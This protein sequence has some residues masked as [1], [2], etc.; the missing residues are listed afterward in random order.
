MEIPKP[1]T[2]LVSYA[3]SIDQGKSEK[4]FTMTAMVITPTEQIPLILPTG[5]AR[6][7]LFGVNHSDDSQIKANI[8]PGV[9]QNSILPY[10][11][12]LF[13]EVIER[14]GYVQTMY[15]YRAF[16]LG[17]SSAPM[18]ATN[19]SMADLT[20]KDAINMVSVK[21]QLL[22]V[23]YAQLRTV[24]ISDHLLM[25]TLDKVLHYQ[26]TKYGEQLN[27]TGGDKWLGV[28]I[29]YPYDNTRIFKQV[30]IP[31]AIPLVK[32]ADFLQQD[33]Q[34]GFYS[35]GMG[36]YY[37][38]G[39]WYIFPP[40]KTGRYE[41]ARKVAN[42]YALPENVFPTLKNSWFLDEKVLTILSTGQGDNID[43]SDIHKLNHG[44]GKRVISSDAIMGEVGRYYAKGQG[45]TTREDSLSEY[46]TSER[47]SGEENIPYH[48]TPTN[49]L[50]KLLS[51]NAYT[52]G[53][54]VSRTWHNSNG[55]EIEPGMPCR[56]YFMNGSDA[57][58]YRE[59]TIVSIRS[60]YQQDTQSVGQP[61]FR[62]HSTL[63]MFLAN[64]V[65]AVEA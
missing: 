6:L 34:F 38:K 37:R 56:Y 30:I 49:N 45:L 25:T 12:N 17:D 36:S 16:P 62:E 8:Q 19:T 50:C 46:K 20:T 13:I 52:D 54:I 28:D 44:S 29:E 65:V 31:A 24:M 59:G 64:D 11:D 41:K 35:R 53:N 15:R 26:L 7:C 4:L 39:M 63:E 43:G 47:S 22:D 33:D 1:L 23:G 57:L 21:F 40:L 27:L 18:T 42:V 55:R 32:L 61:V 9:Y 60:E 14:V 51:Q 58:M 2:N 10:K 5:F 3:N 48:S